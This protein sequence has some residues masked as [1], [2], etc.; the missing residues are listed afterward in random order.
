M[1]NIDAGGGGVDCV[2]LCK[3]GCINIVYL[4]ASLAFEEMYQNCKDSK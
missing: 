3:A 2:C 1:K 4:H